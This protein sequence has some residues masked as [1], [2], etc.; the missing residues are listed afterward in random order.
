MT[1][2]LKW[3]SKAAKPFIEAMHQ[4]LLSG[5]WGNIFEPGFSVKDIDFVAFHESNDDWEKKF[6]SKQ[7]RDNLTNWINKQISMKGQAAAEAAEIHGGASGLIDELAGLDLDDG[8]E[9]NSDPMLVQF[10]SWTV[11][12][13]DIR[14][15]DEYA[16]IISMIPQGL[17]YARI[18][19][20][21][22]RY[23]VVVDPT[24]Y[25]PDILLQAFPAFND[26]NWGGFMQAFAALGRRY[27]TD[28][29]DYQYP[30]RI[31]LLCDHEVNFESIEQNFVSRGAIPPTFVWMSPY[32]NRFLMTTVVK[33][34]DNA[35][36][37]NAGAQRPAN[38]LPTY[39]P[40]PN[41]HYN[42][43]ES[44]TLNQGQP[45]GYSQQNNN[46]TPQQRNGGNHFPFSPTM[47][48]QSPLAANQ[49][50][51]QPSLI[52]TM[53]TFNPDGISQ[54]AMFYQQQQQQQQQQRQ[55]QQQQQQQQRPT[56]QYIQQ[57][58][59]PLGGM[60]H[61]GHFPTP[62]VPAVAGIQHTHSNSEYTE[63]TIEP[64]PGR[65][66]DPDARRPF[67]ET[68]SVDS[69]TNG[70][71]SKPKKVPVK[72]SY[73]SQAC[74]FVRGGA[75]DGSSSDGSMPAKHQATTNT[76]EEDSL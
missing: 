45:F 66:R 26:L 17:Y 36:K 57:P 21:I 28:Q 14:S 37:H 68:V 12:Y 6:T 33:T 55:Q 59:M 30:D 61:N 65:K 31:R 18:I 60:P 41:M 40:T 8:E 64:A 58:P 24:L 50:A 56:V 11:Y 46:V 15:S 2:K 23:E 76:V 54:Q 49:R 71:N 42:P 9:D 73:L 1:N 35:H 48:F 10:P 22:V 32:G 19:G 5:E 16:T 38:P 74:N 44:P 27:I 20:K 70:I 62:G 34:R 63:V 7:C 72:K 25:D 53:P 39:V 75:G 51:F 4:A 52:Q 67:V 29:L 47:H 69:P 43:M 3:T 13:K